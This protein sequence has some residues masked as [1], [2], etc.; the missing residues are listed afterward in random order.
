MTD[1]TK[2][3]EYLEIKLQIPQSITDAVCNFII[4][5]ISNGLILEDEE[6]SPDTI[7]KFYLP[8]KFEKDYKTLLINYFNSVVELK[9]ALS[10]VPEISEKKVQNIEWEDAYKKTITP[11]IITGDVVV[12]PPWESTPP[13]IK[14]DIVI[15]PKMAFGTGKHETTRSCLKIIRDK[16][17]SKM[18]FLDMGC[19]SGILSI[20]ADKL[21]SSYIK[22][23]DYD[24]ISVDNTNENMLFNNVKTKYDVALGS[25]EQCQ[26]DLP[27]DFVCANIIKVTILEMLSGLIKITKDNGILVL[28]GLL[29]KDAD[30]ISEAL[31][32][33][34]QDN[35]E[36]LEDNEWRT[37]TVYKK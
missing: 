24:I 27:Y 20:L 7:I 28:S 4:E 37:F 33:L 13:N 1:T 23:I 32:K 18:S 19:G 8:D 14:Y 29:D 22:A 30:E 6:D 31:K 11:I 21:G 16:F 2:P 3:L 17:R 36:I 26:A 25:I 12:R 35:F 34:N 15:E 9:Q 5:N 10:E